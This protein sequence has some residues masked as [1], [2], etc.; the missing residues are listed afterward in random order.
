MSLTHR[1]TVPQ[2]TS[3]SP[4]DNQVIEPGEHISRTRFAVQERRALLLEE[5]NRMAQELHDTLAQGFA[6]ITL[7]LEAAAALLTESPVQAQLHIRQAQE[8]VKTSL[9]EARRAVWNLC[10]QSLEKEELAKALMRLVAETTAGTSLPVQFRVCGQA[11]SLPL[12]VSRSLLRIAQEALA[13]AITHAHATEIRVEI[14]F[15]TQ[16]MQLRIDDNGRGFS[17]EK[18]WGKG[19]GLANMRARAEG[20]GGRWT[21]RSEPDKGTTVLVSVPFGQ[22]DPAG[23]SHEA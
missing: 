5:R 8:L 7:Q 6:G 3:L 19:L 12:S 13:N 17:P 2:G 9:I 20:L 18:Q 11:I 4:A 22:H 21:L 16:Q 15:E 23:E 10:P 14:A 1:N